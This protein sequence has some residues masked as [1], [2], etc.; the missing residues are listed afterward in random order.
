MHAGN[1]PLVNRLGNLQSLL[2]R[3]CDLPI[4][5]T[6]RPVQKHTSHCIHVRF[7]A[8]T[9]A[10]NTLCEWY[11]LDQTLWALGRMWEERWRRF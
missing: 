7:V 5:N 11:V 4:L 9:H 6:P 1:I 8:R 10:H 3:P 2:L